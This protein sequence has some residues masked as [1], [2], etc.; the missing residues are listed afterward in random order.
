MIESMPRLNL[1]SSLPQ[2]IQR[3]SD[4]EHKIFINI[5]NELAKFSKCRSKQVGC[6]VVKDRRIVSSGCNGTPRG[7]V[8]CCELFDANRMSNPEY[9]EEHHKFSN[10]MECHA[11]QNAIDMA[12]LFGISLE[13]ATFYVSMKPCEQCLKMIA[14]LKVKNI[15][16]DKEYDKFIEYAPYVQQ[17]I[18]DLGI[19]IVKVN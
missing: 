7:A 2:I 12:A 14:N 16:Y 10:A 4:E 17:M 15:Y 11:E 3:G 19:N 8:N 1:Q 6:V 13:G 18:K 9:R 5:A